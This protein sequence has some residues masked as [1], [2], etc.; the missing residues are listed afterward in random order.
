MHYSL[1]SVRKTLFR[2]HYPVSRWEAFI[3]GLDSEALTGKALF[4]EGVVPAPL[5]GKALTGKALLRRLPREA[6]EHR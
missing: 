4:R 1:S 3:R 5:S 6:Y 2:R